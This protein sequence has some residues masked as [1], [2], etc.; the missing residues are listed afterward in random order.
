MTHMPLPPTIKARLL[1]AFKIKNI[2]IRF[3]TIK[4]ILREAQLTY[5][6]CFEG[7]QTRKPFPRQMKSYEQYIESLKQPIKLLGVSK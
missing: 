1:V 3:R 5:P 2:D 4:T 6:E 7:L